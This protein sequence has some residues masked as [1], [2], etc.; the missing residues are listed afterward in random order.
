MKNHEDDWKEELESHL[1]LRADHG[2][3]PE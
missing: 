2:A 3:S 1:T